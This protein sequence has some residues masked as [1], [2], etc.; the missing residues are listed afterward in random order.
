MPSGRQSWRQY[1]LHPSEDE[2]M[3]DAPNKTE[4]SN[5]QLRLQLSSKPVTTN[6]FRQQSLSCKVIIAEKKTKTKPKVFVTTKKKNT[7]LKTLGENAILNSK[8][9]S[10]QNKVTIRYRDSVRQLLFL[11]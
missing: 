4:P 2:S 5:K 6:S 8:V 3:Q 9:F 10:I 11:R 1:V 7:L